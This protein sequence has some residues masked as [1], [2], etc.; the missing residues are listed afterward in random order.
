MRGGIEDF[1]FFKFCFTCT[2]LWFIS[3][4]LLRLVLVW[5]LLTTVLVDAKFYFYWYLLPVPWRF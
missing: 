2:R 4:L 1:L 5:V 3:M